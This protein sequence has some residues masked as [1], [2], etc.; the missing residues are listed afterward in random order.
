MSGDAV[1]HDVVARDAVV[2][3]AVMRN[4]IT[5][6]ETRFIARHAKPSKLLLLFFLE[7]FSR[8]I[9]KMVID[10]RQIKTDSQADGRGTI[11]SST[12]KKVCFS[13]YPFQVD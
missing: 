10:S 11:T 2:R 13:F 5:R 8:R 9:S 12:F 6:E 1:T 3:R 7:R 4:A